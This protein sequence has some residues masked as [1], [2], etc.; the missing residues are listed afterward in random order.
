MTAPKF[1]RRKRLQKGQIV[2]RSGRFYSRYYL[3][4]GRMKAEWIADKSPE[5]HSATCKPVKLLHQGVMLRVNSC[6]DVEDKGSALTLAEFWT[7]TFE[8]W[9]SKTRRKSTAGAYKDLWQRWIEPAFG[10][11]LLANVKTFHVQQLLTSLADKG[12]GRS[13]VSHARSCASA[14]F[15][16]ALN[17]GLLEA[18]P[19]HGAKSLTPAKPPGKTRFYT[20]EEIVKT[21]EA[22][23]GMPDC[24]CAVG[25]SFYC[26]LRTCEIEGLRWSDVSIERAVL[27]VSQSSVR[28]NVGALKTEESHAD[29]PLVRQVL[30]LLQA[31]RAV[32]PSSQQFVFQNSVGNPDSLREMVRCHIKPRLDE[33]KIVWKSWYAGRRGLGTLLARLKGPLASSQALRHKNMK[34]TMESYIKQDR[35]ELVA[36]MKMLDSDSKP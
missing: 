3:D 35:T 9:M 19:V 33:K 24:Q 16:H 22:L 34:V 18:N 5:H 31:W 14:V 6:R 13:T 20:E 30:V 7:G 28:G 23:E 29:I 2:L 12:Y 32:A 36:A 11:E 4:G 15:A 25:L 1:P 21:V 8:P 27:T 17:L 26:G 10:K